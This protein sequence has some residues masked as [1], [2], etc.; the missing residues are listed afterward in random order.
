[1]RSFCSNKITI[2][3]YR[4]SK[5]YFSGEFMKK[6]LL[7]SALI[8]WTGSAYSMDS[9]LI[10]QTKEQKKANLFEHLMTGTICGL[11]SV[12]AYKML[13][14]SNIRS[15]AFGSLFLMASYHF[16]KGVMPAFFRPRF[17][18]PKPIRQMPTKNPPVSPP[19]LPSHQ[20]KSAQVVW[21]AYPIINKAG[22]NLSQAQNY[23][24]EFVN[25][26]NQKLAASGNIECRFAT[27]MEQLK[28]AQTLII[29]QRSV[30]DRFNDFKKS[31]MDAAIHFKDIPSRILIVFI[32][33]TMFDYQA[34]ATRDLTDESENKITY[35]PF[36]VTQ[37]FTQ[38]TDGTSTFVPTIKADA[39][40]T[41]EAVNELAKIT[42]AKLQDNIN[43]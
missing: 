32:D 11:N 23:M 31:L 33:D 21:I 13:P 26:L 41:K 8:F 38:D 15:L 19:T 20:Q 34:R 12:V 22:C 36:P 14:Q 1:M 3:D 17:I 9:G 28:N 5:F 40:M 24:L 4:I 2:V 37:K 42:Q 30:C 43:G 7:I 18:E 29:L 27:N 39:A 35:L 10:N 6:L 25:L 16:I